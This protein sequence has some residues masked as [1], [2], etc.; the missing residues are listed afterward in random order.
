LTIFEY[1]FLNLNEINPNLYIHKTITKFMK[2]GKKNTS[3]KIN[4]Q[5]N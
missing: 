3:M 1:T 4:H 5:Q 2:I